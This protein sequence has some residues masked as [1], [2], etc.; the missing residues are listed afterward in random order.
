MSQSIVVDDDD[1]ADPLDADTV[2]HVGPLEAKLLLGAD[3]RVYALEY[4]RL[5][6]R[7]AN[8]VKVSSETDRNSLYLSGKK[9]IPVLDVTP[10]SQ[11]S[12]GTGKLPIDHL[13]DNL[14]KT[15]VIRRELVMGYVKV[16]D[17]V[18]CIAIN[19]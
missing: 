17:L 16:M 10:S 11:G 6:P 14:V 4:M 5:T 8:Y 1:E 12:K 2:Y 9:G 18:L 3:N 13:D 7:D 19:A 15:Y